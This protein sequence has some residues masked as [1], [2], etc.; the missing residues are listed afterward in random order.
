M[1]RPAKLIILSIAAIVAACAVTFRYHDPASRT[2]RAKASATTIP[3]PRKAVSGAGSGTSCAKA[4]RATRK[5]ATAF[6]GRAEP[7]RQSFGN[8][9]GARHRAAARGRA[10]CPDRSHFSEQQVARELRGAEARRRAGAALAG[11]AAYPRR[12]SRTTIT[13]ISTRRACARSRSSRAARRAF[14]CRS[15]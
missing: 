12:R 13:T 1:A 4:C 6:A 14:T 11:A 3:M 9:G 7:S 10:Q 2:A 5:T 15:G 8:L